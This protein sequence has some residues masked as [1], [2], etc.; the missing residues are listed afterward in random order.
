MLK[1]LLIQAYFALVYLSGFGQ[2][3]APQK[4]GELP[5]EIPEA[6][7]MCALDASHLLLINDSG[8]PAEI[9]VLDTTGRLIQQRALPGLENS[10]WESLA[11]ADG[12]LY[13]GDIGNNA[14]QRRNLHID[15]V[16]LTDF[17]SRGEIK[18][19]PPLNFT[20]PDQ[21][22]YPPPAG[23]RHFDAEAMV[24][25]GDSL[26]IFTKNR[27]EPFD[28]E[29]RCY[30]LSLRGEKQIAR[31]HGSTKLGQGLKES[32]WV[33]GATFWQ[34]QLILL[35]Y[36]KFW[37]FY[38][39]PGQRFF[40][41]KT[42]VF[43]FNHF[44]QKE[45]ISSLGHEIYLADEDSKS[46]EGSLYRLAVEA[47]PERPA[48]PPLGLLAKTVKDTLVLRSDLPDS[49]LLYWE[50]F[51]QGGKRVL[52]GKI[53]TPQG[54]R[55]LPIAVDSLRPAVYVLTLIWGE[56]RFAYFFRKE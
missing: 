20:Y 29:V 48:A 53:R 30:A 55:E 23:F 43:H 10:D 35:G 31:F 49:S 19:L 46:G 42:Q 50:V 47:L 26:Y 11:F 25:S 32:F 3:I 1:N 9:F 52:F 16:D 54:Y 36:D 27:T 7:G 14:N 38:Q 37:V 21:G 39:Y 24:V 13:L 22:S 2:T 12:V 18:V 44:S 15:R 45:A 40:E 8:N 17:M 56:R 33:S 5:E 28:G 51:D 4:L 34:G 6:S 41:G